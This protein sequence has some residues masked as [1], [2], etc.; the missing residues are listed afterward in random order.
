MAVV[1]ETGC[2]IGEEYT[3]VRAAMAMLE[4]GQSAAANL[5][6]SRMI[7]DLAASVG[8]RVFRTAVG[9]ANV[10]AVM[11]ANGCVIGGEGN[12]GVIAPSVGWVRDSLCG[13]AIL[14]DLLRREDRPLS[15]IIKDVPAYAMIKQSIDLADIGGRD[16]LADAMQQLRTRF[17]KERINE[18]DGVRI[19]FESG[20]VHVRASNTEPIARIIAEAATVEDASA[21]IEQVLQHGA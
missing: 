1:D 9:E 20:W 18:S 5:S 10:A 6:T 21:L 7:D 4:E 13:M 11:K 16:G 2:Y 17:E 19:D 3:L 8:G 12:G 14:L 15:D